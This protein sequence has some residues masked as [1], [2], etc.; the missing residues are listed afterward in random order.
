MWARRRSE[1]ERHAAWTR[2]K[3]LA[4]LAG[5]VAIAAAFVVGLV[6]AVTFATGTLGT[7]DATSAMAEAAT[8]GTGSSRCAGRPA[9]ADA[10]AGGGST[11]P[12][13]RPG[14]GGA[15]RA[16]ARDAGGRRRCADGLPADP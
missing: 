16:A 2:R 10:R 9:H 11:G 1:A 13:Q 12:A 3:M 5:G 7:Q 15:D 4:L 6:L 14:P 8:A